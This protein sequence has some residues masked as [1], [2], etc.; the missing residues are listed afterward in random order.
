MTRKRMWTAFT[1]NMNCD[2][3]VSTEIYRQ[4]HHFRILRMP[5]CYK[6]EKVLSGQGGPGKEFTLKS[7]HLSYGH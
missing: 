2:I 7:H 3:I 5:P 6:N 1:G 4:L